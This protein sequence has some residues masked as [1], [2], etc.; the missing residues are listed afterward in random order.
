MQDKAAEIKEPE[1]DSP[2][3]TMNNSGLKSYVIYQ[4]LGVTGVG[5]GTLV[6]LMAM[7]YTST[8]LPSM[9]KDPHFSITPEQESW[10]GAVMPACALL[11]SVASGPLVDR[12]G[13][14]ATLIH[15][16]WPM[17]L[18]WVMI[19]WAEGVG[20]VLAGRMLGGLCVGVQTAA[21]V[22]YVSE[23]LELKLRSALSVIPAATANLGLLVSYGAGNYLTWRG[24]AWLGAVLSLPTVMFF[25]YVP[26]TP[27]YLT[28]T[29]K[30]E[31]S[32][33]A[34]RQLRR[35]TQI[36]E[37]EQRD[38]SNKCSSGEN[39]AHVSMWE[40]IQPPN[41]WPV[42]VAAALMVAQQTTGYMAVVSFTS[43]ILN[44]GG[45]GASN[46]SSSS[47]F[48]GVFN[49]LAT[50]AGIYVMARCE[51]RYLLRVSTVILMA[52]LLAL[53]LYFWALNAGGS[54]AA[55]ANSM[56]LVPV[57]ALTAYHLG[58]SIGWRILPWVFVSEGMPSRVRGKAV[59]VVVA[60]NWASAFLITKTFG[61][62][63]AALGGHTTFL[64]Y[65]VM[66]GVS[67]LFIHPIMPETFRQSITKM[68][69]LYQETVKRK[70]Q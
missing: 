23:I 24:L 44:A 57:M 19:A 67:T 37:E 27:Y 39:N 13:R 52:S 26:E 33:A 40:L 38:I 53:S 48:L 47:V 46:S 3:K 17:M 43:N 68:D 8:A 6:S 66:T 42:G 20:G 10:V 69:Q 31:E 11:G 50:F 70:Q 49:F 35:T 2:E 34:L 16:T 54:V 5:M 21:R 56:N 32:L 36:A 25:Y 18:S 28:R 29:G 22:V 55:I 45:E 1:E 60:I 30:R 51:R 7:G 59:A 58:S 14:R 4:A 41:L 12:L 64:A 63:M 65:A 62:C 9:R 61:W 15:I